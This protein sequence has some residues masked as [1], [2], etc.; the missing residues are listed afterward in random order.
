MCL[1]QELIEASAHSIY[2]QNLPRYR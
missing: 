1:F 2:P